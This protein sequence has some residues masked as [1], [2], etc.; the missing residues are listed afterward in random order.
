MNTVLPAK[1]FRKWG[2]S[3]V[4][5]S[6]CRFK[7]SV[8]HFAFLILKACKLHC[9]TTVHWKP[10]THRFLSTYSWCLLFMPF[11]PSSSIP[12]TRISALQVWGSLLFAHGWSL[13]SDSDCQPSGFSV[14]HPPGKLLHTHLFFF[15]SLKDRGLLYYP[16]WIAVVQTW[17]TAASTC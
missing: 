13:Q 10:L 16:G 15:F 1:K 2:K 11:S 5:I 14:S 3:P 17:P 7:G 8:W 6:R 12:F 9:P 4:M